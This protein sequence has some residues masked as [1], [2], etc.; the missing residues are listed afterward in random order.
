M[1]RKTERDFDKMLTGTGKP[2][3]EDEA[4][5]AQLAKEIEAAF[6]VEPPPARRER[7]MFVHALSGRKASH[8]PSLRFA[9][10]A[11]ALMLL[12]ALTAFFGRSA[13]G[14]DFLFPVRKA[15]AEA[16]LATNPQE[17]IERNIERAEDFIDR[18]EDAEDLTQAQG[19]V[20]RA[21]G[22]LDDARVLADE[23]GPDERRDALEEIRDVE[24]EGAEVL[25]EIIGEKQKESGGDEGS[26]S[27]DPSGS[28][29]GDDSSGSG[30]GDDDSSGSGSDDD[31]SSGSGSG[32]DDSSGSGSGGED[33][34]GSGSGDDSSGSG[35]GSGDDSSGSGSG[36]DDSSGSG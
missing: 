8:M 12:L 5:I 17:E 29:S 34:S 14:G 15:M 31:D 35:S 9:V 25:A 23:L 20:F 7:S 6:A 36:G 27:D 2:G 13:T 30:S 26:G 19:F 32:D 1:T 16:G 10:P 11:T 28:G 21:G 3:D 24:Q 4:S 22:R 18:A 33:S